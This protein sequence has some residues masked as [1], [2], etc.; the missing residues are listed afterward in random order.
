MGYKWGVWVNLAF[1]SI[2]LFFLILG[3]LVA[4]IGAKVAEGKVNDLGGDIGVTAAAGTNWVT[5]A[6]AGIALMVVVLLYWAGRARWLRK[7][8][9]AEDEEKKQ[10]EAAVANGQSATDRPPYNEPG[11]RGPPRAP[12]DHPPY[13]PGPPPPPSPSPSPSPPPMPSGR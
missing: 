11:A 5:L 1:V 7:A 2:A 6:W 3:G 8:K 9:R 13:P 4:V 10:Q 12:L